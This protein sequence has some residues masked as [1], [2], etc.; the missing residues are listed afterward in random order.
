[1]LRHSKKHKKHNTTPNAFRVGLQAINTIETIAAA[2]H[3]S[4]I[5][6]S[7]FFY[8]PLEIFSPFAAIPHH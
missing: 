3:K 6:L 8:I 1:M 2:I 7:L 4:P 5:F